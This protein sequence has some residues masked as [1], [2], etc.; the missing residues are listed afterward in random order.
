MKKYQ[1][2]TFLQNAGSNDLEKYFHLLQKLSQ[3]DIKYSE[4]LHKDL[5]LLRQ[6]G[7]FFSSR[8]EKPE[9]ASNYAAVFQ[10]P[11]QQST[12]TSTK[13]SA[14]TSTQN[15]RSTNKKRSNDTVHYGTNFITNLDN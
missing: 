14:N 7:G 4:I 10:T 11:I 12:N 3:K 13:T 8:E 1:R 5:S 2:L 9:K 6:S 15:N